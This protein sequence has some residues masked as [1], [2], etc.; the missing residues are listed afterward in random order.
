M[1]VDRCDVAIV[2]GGPAGSTCARKLREA[3]LDVVIV[4]KQTF[5][6]DKT[7]AGWV[8]P[9]VWQE[10]GVE[11]NEFAREHVCQP[12]TGFRT[13]MIGDDPVET[14]Y[15]EIVSYG[16]RRCEFD[17]YLLQRCGARLQLQT[18]VKSLDYA[19]GRWTINGMLSTPL[20]IGAGGHFCPIARQLGNRDLEQA[21]TVRA[22]EIEFEITAEQRDGVHVDGAVPEL[23]FCRDL[24]GY[25]WVFRKG[26]H[27]NIG[28]GR[29]TADNISTH[30]SE[31][32]DFLRQR[33][34]ITFEI[35]GRFHGHAYQLYETVRP[36]LIGDGVLL[37]GDAAG[38]AYPQSGEGI[39]PAVESA[40]LAADV[41]LSTGGEFDA[42]RLAPYAKLIEKQLGE[43]RSRALSGWLPAQWL[44][45]AASKAL[46]TRWFSR[47]VVL[48]RWFLHRHQPAQLATL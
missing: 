48:D 38:L 42:E 36:K 33:G 18:P 24:K 17:N 11:P 12:I 25:G 21:S 16:I 13:G 28:L 34:A 29:T 23:Y 31:F 41:I 40:L 39:R 47:H 8:T 35:E 22:Q 30:V 14:H 5:P 4:D 26:N 19:D 46:G 44:Q 7:C 15:G 9:P 32:C 20:L 43:P 27:L 2:G 1:S 10:L 37:I 45:V 3:G 6:R